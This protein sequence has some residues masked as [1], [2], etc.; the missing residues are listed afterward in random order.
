MPW[1]DIIMLQSPL[2]SLPSAAEAWIS[3]QGTRP[4]PVICTPHTRQLQPLARK[5]P[6][7]SSC[8]EL[9]QTPNFPGSFLLFC[10]CTANTSGSN[11]FL[12]IDLVNMAL[13]KKKPPVTWGFSRFTGEATPILRPLL[14][15]ADLTAPGYLS[16]VLLPTEDELCV[17]TNKV[18]I[19]PFLML[20]T[21]PHE[22]WPPSSS[23]SPSS[24]P[25]PPSSQIN[26][27]AYGCWSEWKLYEWVLGFLS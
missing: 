23:P 17:V 8:A 5:C 27:W 7:S 22:Q 12:H 20:S 2:V 15:L 10:L 3:S 21:R 6:L 1:K 14:R 19:F 26:E 13:L 25:P 24:P 16:A 4:S 9:S 18:F 11:A